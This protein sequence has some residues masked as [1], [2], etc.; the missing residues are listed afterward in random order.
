MKNY[1]VI[2]LFNDGE[3]ITHSVNVSFTEANK[4][5]DTISKEAWTDVAEVIIQPMKKRYK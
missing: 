4:I 2:T 5:T 1:Q 3:K